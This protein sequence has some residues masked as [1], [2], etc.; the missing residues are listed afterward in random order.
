MSTT[1]T[2][3]SAKGDSD[4]IATAARLPK[5]PGGRRWRFMV[6]SSFVMKGIA[7]AKEFGFGATRVGS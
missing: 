2:V 3:R 5:N 1:V 7:I 4:R 6:I